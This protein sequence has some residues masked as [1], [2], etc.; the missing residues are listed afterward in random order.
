M[1]KLAKP[2]STL[3]DSFFK[4]LFAAVLIF[5]PLYPKFPL[6]TVPFT[7]VSI[8]VEDFLIAL[9][10]L[11]FFARLI[12]QKKII[13]PKVTL[14]FAVFAFV[15]L[16]SSLSAI[17]ITKNVQPLL[18]FLHF[19]RRIEYMSVFFLIYFAAR[20]SSTRRY[21]LELAILPAIGVFLYGIAQI[22]FNAPVIST[23]DSESSKGIAMYLRPGVTLNSTFGG[24]YDLAVYLTMIMTFLVAITGSLN[25]WLKR[26]PFLILF[27]VL[28]WL[29]MQAG[30]RISLVSLVVAVC[31]VSYFYRRFVLGLIFLGVIFAFIATSSQYIDRFKSI[32]RVFTVKTS[33][34]IFPPTYA[35]TPKILTPTLTP[36]PTPTPEP[37]RPI[38][39]DR[40]TS[41]RFDVE[42]PRA[43]RAFYKNPILGTGFSS[44]TLATD[45]DYLRTLGEMGL[46]GLL[47][48]LALLYAMGKFLVLSV[49]KVSG[50]DKIIIISAIGIFASFLTSAIFID[51]FESSKIAI[52]FW[53]YMGL[54]FSTKKI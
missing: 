54:A 15:A 1:Q 7:Y 2:T 35:A 16:V 10:W 20:E 12:N 37:L 46:L 29:F 14:Q 6:F 30:S 38:Q 49:N 32:F 43:M 50:I 11:V 3:L 51:V 27:V 33:Q 8:R 18:V 9:V 40:S 5:I 19:F 34:I 22:Y 41:I 24:H 39:Q 47:S 23:M 52:L 25:T 42:W 44:I 4:Y 13:F 17:L 48:F 36:K 28:L 31:L 53:A 45:N 21:Y 26:L